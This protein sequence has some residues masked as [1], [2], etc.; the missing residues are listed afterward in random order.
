MAELI[1]EAFLASLKHDIVHVMSLFEGYEDDG[2]TSIGRFDTTTPVSA[3]LF[4]LIPLISPDQ[5]LKTNKT[6]D[7]YYQRKIAYLRRSS[8]LL[9]ISES[10]RMEGLRYLGFPAERII[11]TPLAADDCFRPLEI[12]E[13]WTVP[14]LKKHGI[15]RSFVLYSGGADVRKNLPRLI[16]AYALLSPKLRANH[17]LVFVG[18][19]PGGIVQQLKQNAKSAGLD[20]EELVFTGYVTDDDLTRLYNLC[21]LYIFL[22]W[23]EGFG[24]PALETMSCGAAVIASNSS[25][26]PEVIGR[27]DALF[28]PYS[29][30]DIASKLSTLLSDDELRSD[31]SRHGLAQAKYFSWDTSARRAILAFE[32]AVNA[33]THRHTHAN[34]DL[35]LSRLITSIATV[36]TNDIKNDRLVPVAHSI[37]VSLPMRR[38]KQL[39]ID[40]SEL[41]QRDAKTGVQRVTRSTLKQFRDYPP[42]GYSVEPVYAVIDETGY[43][44]A[45]TFTAQFT[46]TEAAGDDDYIEYSVG[47][48]F[49]GLDLQHHTT[50]VY[51]DLLNTMRRQG[52]RVY[53]VVYDLLPLQFPQYWPPIHQVNMIHAEWINVIASFDGAICISR[54]VADELSE[55]LAQHG[56]ERYQPFR[57]SW[58][59]LGADVEN[60]APTLG[61]TEDSN[62]IL[63]S[64]SDRQSFLMV[65]TI[66]PR[67]GHAQTLAAFEQLWAEGLDIN[68]VIVGKEG[69]MV[70]ELALKLSQHKES[71]KHL[72]WLQG[73]SDEYL[74]KVYAAS[75]CLIAASEGEGFGLR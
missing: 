22:S 7:E 39:F 57:I 46:N 21:K 28:D 74:E 38:Q 73:I 15:T 24:L 37:S 26:L 47:D 11:N 65:G 36:S 20:D 61:M 53:F 42:A 59:H 30:A 64:V 3:S 72:F 13:Q 8:L 44:Y 69:W 4:D 68:L 12:R 14:F 75:S 56:P 62:S 32:I 35:N 40:I 16:Q 67:K 34:Y 43:R 41:T 52:V 25:S 18:R 29:E 1:R 17:Q 23:H 5:Y 55:W 2:V 9:S 33:S 6:Y 60:S 66:E 51:A 54:A 45:R 58:F 49:L 50:R 63:K 48:I 70:E 19:I 71:K 27:D 31:F 10:S